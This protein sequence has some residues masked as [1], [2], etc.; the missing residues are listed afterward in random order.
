MERL[1][2]LICISAL[3]LFACTNSSINDKTI[4]TL[5]TKEV[6]QVAKPFSDLAKMDTFRVVLSGSKPKDMQLSFSIV[7][8]NGK[9][10]Y[11]KDLRASELF[12][13]YGENVDLK[14]DAA[15]LKFLHE[16]L[17][18]FLD[19]EN[20]LEPAITDAEQPDQNTI[21]KAFYKEL[22]KSRLNGFKYSLGKESQ[23]YIAWSESE[24]KVKIYYKCC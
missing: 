24:Q 7:A 4:T 18:L 13:N 16:E 22:K 14:N 8:Y 10:I 19:S 1:F 12:K 15:K 6:K 23:V 3:F 5:N 9:K 17:N 21:D 11:Q 2:T 20:F